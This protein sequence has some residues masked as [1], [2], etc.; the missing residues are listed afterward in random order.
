MKLTRL[1]RLA[2]WVLHRSPRITFLAIK[3]MHWD[4][5]VV[6]TSPADPAAMHMRATLLRSEDPP[7][8]AS[9]MLERLYHMPD[10]E[11]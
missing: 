7:T 8:P 10:A 4:K 2:L 3:A 9:M 6:A 11:K 5:T 1:E